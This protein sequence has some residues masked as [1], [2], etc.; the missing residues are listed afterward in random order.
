MR[1]VS[2][3]LSLPTPWLLAAALSAPVFAH[4]FPVT[5]PIS[6][7]WYTASRSGEGW[8]VQVL[9]DDRAFVAWF[10]Y[11]A[12]GDAGDQAWLTGVGTIEN[13]LID[14]TN[15]QRFS[16]PQFGPGFDPGAAIAE[17][18]G[19]LQ[20]AFDGCDL[21]EISFTGPPAYGNEVRFVERLTRIGGLHCDD[22]VTPMPLPQRPV[23]SAWYDPSHNGE[24]WFL[25]EL[26]DGRVNMY[27]FTY[28]ATGQ[29]AWMTGVGTRSGNIVEFSE[30]FIVTGPVFGQGFDTNEVVLTDW[31]EMT[32]TLSNCNQA[33]IDYVS[34]LPDFGSGQLAPV[35]LT[36][37]DG[38][39]CSDTPPLVE[40]AWRNIVVSPDPRT[41]V[42][43]ARLGNE[44]YVIGGFGGPTAIESYDLVSGDWNTHAP[45]PIGRNHAMATAFEDEVFVF[46]GY[47]GE[48]FGR[49][50]TTGFAYSP[51]SNSWRQLTDI[52]GASVAGGRAVTLGDHIYL[53]G[54]LAGAMYRYHPASDSYDTLPSPG[55]ERDHSSVVALNGEIWV[56]GGRSSFGGT[57]NSVRIYNPANEQWRDGPAMNDARSG[58]GAA[59]VQGQI[60]VVGGE[61]FG[62]SSFSLTTLEV[63]APSTGQWHRGPPLPVPLHGLGA[64]EFDGKLF[65]AGGSREAGLVTIAGRN[66]LYEP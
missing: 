66:F 19:T 18:W 43:M 17:D 58:F 8:V 36:E 62:D 20:L 61:V 11:P 5:G 16:G 3:I 59:V 51:T 50:T 28:D 54:G 55:G 10:T 60:M 64:V 14:I 6:G 24:G 9:K 34:V 4:D 37:L 23:S 39:N 41:E 48:S 49:N 7:S 52:P 26:G 45:L 46:G 38:V 1:R 30:V 42:T 63:F 22:P 56:I 65:T 57:T 40:G 53:A 29:Q 12:A 15:L 2:D 21:G 33:T 35:R 27:W 13:N 31:G 44:A 47:T 25:E 32:F